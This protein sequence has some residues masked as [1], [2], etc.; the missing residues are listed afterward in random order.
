MQPATALG[1]VAI[2]LALEQLQ[3]VY[4]NLVVLALLINAVIKID[5]DKRIIS[6]EYKSN[7]VGV[8]QIIEV[9]PSRGI[10]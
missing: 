4:R 10:V 7:L 1:N 2:R 9:V 8:L 5:A 6:R 3:A